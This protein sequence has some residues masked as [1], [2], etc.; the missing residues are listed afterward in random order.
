[1]ISRRSLFI[2]VATSLAACGRGERAR[3]IASADLLQVTADLRHQ[4]VTALP[5]GSDERPTSPYCG[6]RPQFCSAS[7]VRD[8]RDP[9]AISAVI[10]FVNARLDGWYEPWYGLPVPNLEIHFWQ[11]NSRVGT[12]GSGTNFFSR[13]GF[14]HQ[15]IIS[16]SAAEIG[17][18]HRLVHIL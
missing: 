14:P 5:S 15:K 9:T 4:I 10:S 1:M 2:F 13:G 3:S 18:F 8:V 7:H 6:G 16:A 12:F 17:E 11:G